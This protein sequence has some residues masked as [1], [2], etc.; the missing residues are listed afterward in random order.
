MRLK[1]L[2]I[3][4]LTSCLVAAAQSQS[5]VDPPKLSNPA[6]Q[7]QQAPQRSE[8]VSQ[9]NEVED[10]LRRLT[11]IYS[12]IE[13]QYADPISP[14]K[15][16]YQGAIPGM[17]RRLDPYSVFFD[18][19]QFRTLQ[20]HQQ[21]KTEGFGTIVSVMPGRVVV[22]EAFIGSP[23]ARAGIQSGDEIVEVN[24]VPIGRLGVEEIV[25]V[26]SAARQQRAEML[27]LRPYSRRVE[28]IVAT[29]AEMSEASVDRAFFLDKGIGYLRVGS[30]EEK[31][32]D[33]LKEALGKWGG[34]LRGLV[35]D[36]RENHG[37]LVTSAIDTAGL[38]LPKGTL[39]LTAKGR[40]AEQK[41]FSV[42]KSDPIGQ[43]LPLVVLVSGKTASAA[44]I[45]AGALQDHGRAKLVGDRTFGKGTVQS[46][47]PLSESTGLALATARYVTPSGRYIERTRTAQGGIEPDFVVSPYLYNDFQAFLESHT[48]FLEFARKL[49]SEGRTFKDDFEVTPQLVDEFRAFLSS[50]QLPVSQ[51]IWSD[52]IGYIRTHLKIEIANLT[53]GVAKGDQVAAASD[54]QI[55]RAV[56]LLTREQ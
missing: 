21:A 15:E 39:V 52:N 55:Q 33:E 26:L 44:E 24:G 5:P 7:P 35:L 27:V 4:I 40:T 45:V 41:Q 47:Y 12:V 51:K 32:A 34:E 31:T 1:A 11:K 42:E 19:D 53:L 18:A 56:E 3:V 29:P 37:G 25:E 36:L 13:E 20:Q 2:A 14:D 17:L 16:I 9:Q 8:A 46:V 23:A 50:L 43:R 28:R 49:R 38:F 6:Q 22:L 54:P 30:F 48:L 10:L